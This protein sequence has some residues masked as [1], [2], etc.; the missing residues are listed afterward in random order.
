[1]QGLRRTKSV[2]GLDLGAGAV[3][4]VE[5]AGG[6][7]RSCAFAPYTQGESLTGKSIAAA[8]R[9]ALRQAAPRATRAVVGLNA[10]EVIMHRFTLPSDLP[11]AEIEEQARAQAGQAV[12]YPLDE[13]CYDYLEEGE[14][15][16]NLSY[17]MGIARLEAVRALCRPVED[18]GL[19]VAAVDIT[20]FAIQRAVSIPRAEDSALAVLDGGHRQTRLTLYSG[21]GPAFQHSYSFGCEELAERLRVAYGL[22]NNDTLKAVEECALPGG[23][24]SRIRESFLRDLAR[25]TERA[26]QLC[27]ASRHDTRAPE[28]ILLWGG[29]AL[30]HGACEVLGEALGMP[31]EV[32]APPGTPGNDPKAP[33]VSPVLLGAYAL[34][35]NDH[36]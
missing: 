20:T 1:M 21:N 36:A 8:I 18:A 25:H 13:A 3:K 19:K 17:C 10:A 31:V 2:V 16:R 32:A 26:L 14:G 11:L 4:A 6:A 5:L 30:L 22:S 27:L 24:V 12:P 29:A 35:L 15:E 7:Y 34:A 9:C 28:K 33:E 23:P